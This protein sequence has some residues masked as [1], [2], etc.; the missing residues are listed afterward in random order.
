[1]HIS[2]FFC[3]TRVGNVGQCIRGNILEPPAAQSYSQCVVNEKS[4]ASFTIVALW[5]IL[6]S[7]RESSTLE[8][9]G[10]P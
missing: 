5:N 2:S 10:V 4:M 6:A 9:L 8:V 3:S 7:L 1:M